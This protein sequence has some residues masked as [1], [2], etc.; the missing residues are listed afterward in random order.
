MRKK[1]IAIL[2]ILVIFIISLVV[3][4]MFCLSKP[5]KKQSNTLKIYLLGGP[6][7]LQSTIDEYEKRYPGKKIEKVIFDMNSGDGI[8]GYVKRLL[9]D[10]LSGDGPDI[11]MLD[12]MSA[13]KLEKSR[14]LI[15]LKPLIAKD[16]EFNKD[17]YNMKVIKAG[18][19]EGKQVLMPLDYSVNQYITTKELLKLN[20]IPLSNAKNQTEF[21]KALEPYINTFDS[22]KNKFIFGN[23]VTVE[24]FIAA[25]GIKFIDYDKKEVYFDKP[26]FRKVIE[27]YKKLYNASRK[28]K[29]MMGMSGTD[30]FDG[31]KTGNVLLSNDPIDMRDTFFEFESLISQAIKETQVIDTIPSYNG[32]RKVVPIVQDSLS[33]SRNTE[34][35]EDAYNFIKIAISEDIQKSK[36]QFQAIPVNKKAA[37]ELEDYYS[38]NLVNQTYEFSRDITIKNKPLSDNFKSYFNRIID[39]LDDGQVTN[40]DV[41]DMIMQCFDPYFEGKADYESCINILINKV[42]IYINE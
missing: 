38:K 8:E 12:S 35:V 15:D 30:G 10:T 32:S 9:T 40:K 37:R 6:G 17:D 29:D 1:R 4:P 31:I 34:N 33:I 20:K 39:D 11:L 42:K 5:K 13:R 27:N 7:R 41:G 22:D 14:M 16:K 24:S 23:Q 19:Y 26:E 18:M 28:Q 2:I 36:D 21:V 25:S 3:L